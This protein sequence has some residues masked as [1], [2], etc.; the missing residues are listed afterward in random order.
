MTRRR[1]T[2]SGASG[3]P[4]EGEVGV[5]VYAIA[6]LL[7]QY[8]LSTLSHYRET[9]PVMRHKQW[10]ADT[11]V[12]EVELFTPL[13]IWAAA[14]SFL[15]QQS[16][17]PVA[18]GVW[19]FDELEKRGESDF[20]SLLAEYWPDRTRPLREAPEADTFKAAI[21]ALK[22]AQAKIAAFP[23]NS[24][25]ALKAGRI[26]KL[27]LRK[28]IVEL[29]TYAELAPPKPKDKGGRPKTG[30]YEFF[31]DAIALWYVD[32]KQWPPREQF[33]GALV[34][35]LHA[36]GADDEIE[37][38]SFETFKAALTATKA[39]YKATCAKSGAL[40]DPDKARYEVERAKP[41]R[42]PKGKK[43]S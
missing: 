22:K 21:N 40:I 31:V 20:A 43:S 14:R 35:L 11:I 15:E 34:S 2:P 3:S 19:L 16:T 32:T 5:A 6:D 18:W 39:W 36:L 8:D 25:Y 27:A 37:G 29:E 17:E 12:A 42:R 26:A 1:S 4:L 24:I 30:G 9:S 33:H 41:A 28:L 7:A 10:S 23:A 38:T 13:K